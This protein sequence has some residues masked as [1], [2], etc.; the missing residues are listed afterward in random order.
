MK[1]ISII[2]Y[3]SILFPVSVTFNVD[4]QEQILSE[5]GV[6]LAGSDLDTETFFGSVDGLEIS[7]WMPDEII[8]NDDDYDG[9]Y[10]ITVELSPNTSYIY[11]FINGYE[12]ELQEGEDRTLYTIDEDIVLGTTCFNKVDDPCTEIDNSLVE[13]VFTVDMKEVELSEESISV[14]GT[15]LDDYTNFGYYVDTLEPIPIYDSSALELIEIDEDVYSIS[16]MVSPG[17]NYQ[18]RFAYGNEIENEIGFRDLIVSEVSGFNLNEVCFNSFED[19]NDYDTTI[20]QLIFK[21][22]LSNAIYDNGFEIGNQ[23]VV[24]WGFGNTLAEEREDVLTFI[25]LSNDYRAVVYLVEVDLDMGLYYQFYKII[26]EIDSREIF[27]NFDYDGDDVILAERRFFS[28]EG[29]QDFST[30]SIIDDVD[31]NVDQRR[32]PVFSNTDP[33]GEEVEV[34]WTIDLSPAYYQILSGDILEDIQGIYNVDNVDSLYEW[35]VWINGPASYPA[36]GENWTQWG[37]TLFNTNSKKMWDDGTHGDTIADDHIYTIK[38]TYDASAKIGQEC[39]FGIKGGDNESSYGLNHYENINPNDPNIH[40]YWGSINPVFYDS[41]DYDLNIPIDDSSCTV[42]D[43][44]SDG[45]INVIDIVS[46]V[47]IILNTNPPSDEEL[48]LADIN[49]DGIVNVIDIVS[50]VSAILEKI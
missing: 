13:V 10:T 34:T 30:V 49:Q 26:D 45:I 21:P 37:S 47:S 32:M 7:P 22:D 39:K 46:I 4:M 18:Y 31:S 1:K 6:H 43:L 25:P 40:I 15:N 2:I 16:I 14:I 9:V 42:M 27:F 41:W 17:I 23:L 35:G 48:C 3:L 33:I 11:K 38:L 28:F 44:N 19:C 20:T 29:I 36:N 8:M 50:V 5:D 12:Y 24:R